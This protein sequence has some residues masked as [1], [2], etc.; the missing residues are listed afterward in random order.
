MKLTC[1]FQAVLN[2]ILQYH[3]PE[4]RRAPTVVWLRL[5]NDIKDI[6]HVRYIAFAPRYT[7]YH[8]NFRNII[9]THTVIVIATHLGQEDIY[10]D[11]H[12][13][14]KMR[15]LLVEFFVK[16]IDPAGDRSYKSVDYYAIT[17]FPQLLLQA[18]R[19]EELDTLLTGKLTAFHAP[20]E[21]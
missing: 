11:E 3:Q 13:L 14:M 7:F 1:I 17:E 9:S 2:E 6:I 8:K 10:N 21:S 15:N 19:Y 18:K 20:S 12:E 5:L 4:P 16:Q